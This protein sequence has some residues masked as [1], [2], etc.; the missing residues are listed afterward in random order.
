MED[1]LKDPALNT[2][3]KPLVHKCLSISGPKVI[4]FIAAKPKE[5]TT[6]VARLFAQALYSETAQ[7]ILLVEVSALSQQMKP[8][9]ELIEAAASNDHAVTVF[10]SISPGISSCS[11]TSS[12][13]RYAQAGNV[14]QNHEFWKTLQ[15]KFEFILIDAPSLQSTPDGISFARTSDITVL[16]VEAEVTRKQ[17]I[18]HLRDTLAAAGAKI[19][20]VVLNKRR[21]Y[22][23]EKI[24]QNL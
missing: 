7:D 16:V 24:Y 4:T 14:M 3:I 15:G 18:E 13:A 23:P 12:N 17:V 21:F 6:T 8:K 9:L 5:G 22:I 10:N 20:G 11:W 1:L 2:E 19:A